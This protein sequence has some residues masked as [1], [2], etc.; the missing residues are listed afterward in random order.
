MS[1]ESPALEV[2]SRP[3]RSG[4]VIKILCPYYVAGAVIGKGMFYLS[5]K[6]RYHQEFFLVKFPPTFEI[7]KYTCH[8]MLQPTSQLICNIQMN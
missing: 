1:E 7:I 2:N 4:S 3:R 5:D 8:A 6:S